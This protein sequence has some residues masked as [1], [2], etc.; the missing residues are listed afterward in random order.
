ML[1]IKWTH[2]EKKDDDQGFASANISNSRVE[3]KNWKVLWIFAK[4]INKNSKRKKKICWIA[5]MLMEWL[6][7]TVIFVGV[8]FQ[9]INSLK[10]LNKCIFYVYILWNFYLF[11]YMSYSSLHFYSYK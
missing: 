9:W 3:G 11:L 10:F 6:M 2:H 5:Y 1:N 8:Y 4:T 7:R